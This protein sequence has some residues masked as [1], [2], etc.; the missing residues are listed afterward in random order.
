MSDTDLDASA[1]LTPV[2]TTSTVRPMHRRWALVVIAVA[3]AALSSSCANSGSD[4]QPAEST[5]PTT[6]T[7]LTYADLEAT[8]IT[9]Q[10]VLE[11]VACDGSAA[12]VADINGDVC[13]VLGP[14]GGDGTDLRDAKVYADGVGIEVAVRA[15]S[16]EALNELFNACYDA[17][18]TC[19]AS[20]SDGQGYAAIVI[21]GQVISTPAVNERDLASTPFVITG[22][23]NQNQA[24]NIA[25]AINR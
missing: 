4:A 8:D 10:P 9:F 21:D 25:T 18:S 19:P 16:A 1:G 6:T 13:Y 5:A 2:T 22:D 12:T 3:V 20:S 23:F 24:T 15:D 7:M 14:P 17:E 11:I